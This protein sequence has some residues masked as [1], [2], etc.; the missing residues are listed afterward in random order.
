MSPRRILTLGIIT[1]AIGL[2][3]V[4]SAVVLSPGF[5]TQYLSPDNVLTE[6][7]LKQ[8]TRIRLFSSII[9]G[10]LSIGGFFILRFRQRIAT[11]T[12]FNFYFSLAIVFLFLIG[13]ILVAL[14]YLLPRL[15]SLYLGTSPS[16][17]ISIFS[18]HSGFLS[19]YFLIPF[20]GLALLA[21][22][23][24]SRGGMF[25]LWMCGLLLLIFGNLM[26]GGYEE[27][28]IRPF[29]RG[30]VQYY[31]D[32]VEIEDGTDWFKK[33]NA[34]QPD[35]RLHSKTHPP[36]A[37]LIHYWVMKVFGLD[38]LPIFFVLLTSLTVPLVYRI[39]LE[40]GSQRENAFCLSLLF[41]VLPAFNIF[42]AVCLD[43]VICTFM[44]LGLLGIV[45]MWKRGLE[46]WGIVFLALGLVV[47]NLISFGAV[48]LIGVTGIFIVKALF[49]DHRISMSIGPIL[50]IGLL[51]FI[52]L[53]LK[54]GFSYDHLQ[55]F[56]TASRLENPAG[57][58]LF[59]Q[60][61]QYAATRIEGIV[62]LV[63]FFSLA[64]AALFIFPRRFK[65]GLN[66]EAT[67]LALTGISVL[68][69]MLLTGAY[70]TGETARVCLFIYPY[71][72]LFFVEGPWENLSKIIFLALT[73]TALMQ[74]IGN[75][76]W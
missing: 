64:C 14:N 11:I 63:L 44:T 1:I 65:I 75:Y 27:G 54:I 58:Y 4:I 50:C 51:G 40:L 56:S 53:G 2:V 55:A 42:G 48:F 22:R 18:L 12:S 47:S 61:I 68:A 19:W 46:L 43:G 62:E 15:F 9:G 49:F 34:I 37:V 26:Q 20:V 24:R 10:L 59:A 30:N 13:L 38:G 8:L 70:R 25:F 7:G 72:M 39:F 69:A 28:F 35:L 52:L 57:F 73:Q 31:H 36:F 3:A 6:V 66:K 76:F 32:A 74:L 71:L 29:N 17:P 60:P 41:A 16:F 23:L 21:W 45:R 67:F 33:F 5:A